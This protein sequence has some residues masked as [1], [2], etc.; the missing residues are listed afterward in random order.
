MKYEVVYIV[1]PHQGYGVKKCCW[2]LCYPWGWHTATF[3][4]L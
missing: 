4:N 2:K 3:Y 1:R